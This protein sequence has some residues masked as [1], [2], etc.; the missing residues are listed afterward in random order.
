MAVI[1]LVLLAAAPAQ[2]WT[3][4]HGGPAR[5]GQVAT[6]AGALDVLSR[7]QIHAEDLKVTGLPGALYVRTPQGLVALANDAAGA[8]V[9]LMWPDGPATPATQVPLDD[10]RDA[11]LQGYSPD[12]D[13]LTLCTSGPADEA[14]FQV[15][16]ARTGRL[17]FAA[18]LAA[19]LDAAA[20]ADAATGTT[21]TCGGVALD[22]GRAVI[23]VAATREGAESLRFSILE[24]DLGRGDAQVLF[25]RGPGDNPQQGQSTPLA[26]G[27]DGLLVATEF[28]PKAATMVGDGLVVTGL[29]PGRDGDPPSAAVFWVPED[30]RPA[31]IEGDT[32]LVG[33]VS[34]VAVEGLAMTRVGDRL[35]MVD[36]LVQRPARITPLPVYE[37]EGPGFVA[38]TAAPAWQDG[39]VFMPTRTGIAAVSDQDLS[40]DWHWPGLG[41]DWLLWNVVVT[42]DNELLGIAYLDGG[43]G[44][45]WH[46]DA[47][48]VR[49]D[50]TTGR[51]V[52]LLPLPL[53]ETGRGPP[54]IA[55]GAQAD[56]CPVDDLPLRLVPIDAGWLVTTS[57][58][59]AV[60]LGQG[61]APAF[62]V[63]HTHAY[64]ATG[65]RVQL[66]VPVAPEIQE[67]T[68]A[69]GDGDADRQRPADPT[70]GLF[71][72][73]EGPEELVFTHAY[74]IE[75][76]APVTIT[77]VL[78]DGTTTTEELVF[79]VGKT[80]PPDLNFMQTQFARENQDRTWGVIGV[81]VAMLGG[82][83]AFVFRKRR[84]RRIRRHLTLLDAI[85]ERSLL[86]PEG[87]LKE[88]DAQQRY[89]RGLLMDGRIDEGEYQVASHRAA[90]ISRRL[91]RRLLGPLSADMTPEYRGQI[92]AAFEDGLLSSNEAQHLLSGVD[93][94][95]G[96]SKQQQKRLRSL[97]RGWAAEF[98]T[99]P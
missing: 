76:D 94:E 33:A 25:P 41:R 9:L 23:P 59:D 70:R 40:L 96:L 49:L 57:T 79:H 48:L 38:G 82:L 31:L 27:E 3:Q 91:H 20:S 46:R 87:A 51:L 62:P 32:P 55:C 89:L 11:T 34:A 54:G 1:C 10:C 43:E 17:R 13:A 29:H 85:H 8:C 28:F 80:P 45:A 63:Q 69:W 14:S 35:L 15:R 84:H 58:G 6:E 5:T 42:E 60:L 86:D 50:A 83:Y 97:I 72:Q 47:V 36:P 90:G 67:V 18:S 44:A 81:A 99:L 30:S 16:D 52:Q 77:T 65:E 39:T 78:A 88:L 24:M 64:P 75:G 98:A 95:T 61:P 53:R 73:E 12:H 26:T 21:W 22:G 71:R 37:P 93:A 4:W 74:G 66:T 7:H 92:E 2:A 68:V 19:G 56:V